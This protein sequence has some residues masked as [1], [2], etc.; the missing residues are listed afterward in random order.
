LIAQRVA[1]RCIVWLDLTRD[2]G[3]LRA[4]R[5]L[6][7]M[8]C[9]NDADENPDENTAKQLLHAHA[10]QEWIALHGQWPLIKRDNMPA[11]PGGAANE[12]SDL[13]PASI[14]TPTIEP[15]EEREAG[16]DEHGREEKQSVESTVHEV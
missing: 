9:K 11:K 10:K 1:V 13:R 14:R 6:F 5:M 2:I 16:R 12:G 15:D 8:T 3:G 7:V 4:G